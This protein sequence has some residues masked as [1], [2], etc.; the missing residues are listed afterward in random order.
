M[1]LFKMLLVGSWHGGLSD[2]SIEEMANINLHVMRFL[3]LDVEDDVLSL[4]AFPFQDTIDESPGLRW[5]AGTDQP[6]NTGT[7]GNGN[8]RLSH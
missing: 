8:K 4:D 7:S 3:G 6:I 1:L 2:E 5:F